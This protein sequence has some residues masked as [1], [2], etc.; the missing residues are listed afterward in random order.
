MGGGW[1]GAW[2]VGGW[3]K[4]EGIYVYVHDS[5]HCRAET[6]ATL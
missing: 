4:R 6:N 5:L 3:F 2:E 1:E